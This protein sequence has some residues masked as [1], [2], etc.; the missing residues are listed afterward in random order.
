MRA[1][2]L[3]RE[4]AAVVDDIVRAATGGSANPTIEERRA[5]LHKMAEDYGPPVTHRGM[6]QDHLFD[7]PGGLIRA[8]VYH[9]EVPQ[10][11]GHVIV[12]LHGGGWALGGP[13]TYE[14]QCRAICAA[15]GTVLID[16]DYRLAPEHRYPAALE[17]CAT[18]IRWSL[19]HARSIGLNGEKVVLI[20]DSAGGYLVALC[21]QLVPQLVAGQILIYPVLSVGREHDRPS[22]QRLG[23]GEYFLTF[24]AIT[25]AEFEF[26]RPDAVEDAARQSPLLA[27]G[28]L[29][30]HVPPTLFILPEFDPLV[31]EG[32]DYSERLTAAGVEV[33]TIVEGGTIHGFI[34]F[35]GAITAGAKYFERIGAFVRSLG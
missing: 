29:L 14:R 35:S 16:V 18:A 23:S 26:L 7:G 2:G 11:D 6:V 31:D 17:D 21:C 4:S 8:R 32:L 33:T 28:Q 10:S 20:G 9:P 25:N 22:R 1:G 3:T 5:A 13:D 12:H 15:A 24:D 34:L 27:D 30:A 19:D